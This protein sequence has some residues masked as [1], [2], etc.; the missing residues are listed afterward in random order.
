MQLRLPDELPA[1]SA[2]ALRLTSARTIR[3]HSNRIKCES[4]HDQTTYGRSTSYPSTAARWRIRILRRFDAA[5]HEYPSCLPHLDTATQGRGVQYRC[6]GAKARMYCG[7][8]VS[9][10]KS[11]ETIK[12]ET[13]LA[14]PT[15]SRG[16]CPGRSS[17]QKPCNTE[18]QDS[19]N[20]Y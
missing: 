15:R 17:L 18:K 12:K 4:S 8:E 9:P 14:K 6:P 20:I 11:F 1:T 19:Q 13:R 16:E 5:K 7:R 3:T 2:A 10:D